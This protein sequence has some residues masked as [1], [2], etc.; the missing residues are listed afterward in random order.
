MSKDIFA[1]LADRAGLQI[2]EQQLIDWGGIHDLDCIT[3]LRKTI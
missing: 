2:L 1:H 3:L